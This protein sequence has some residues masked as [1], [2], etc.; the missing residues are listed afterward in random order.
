MAQRFDPD[1]LK[2]AGEATPLVEGILTISGAALAVFSTSDSGLLAYNSGE[3]SPEVHLEWRDR[4]GEILSTV[5]EPAIFG[6]IALSPDGSQVISEIVE[7]GGIGN[8]W[9]TDLETGLRNR[10]TFE[11]MSNFGL[12]W[13]SDGEQLFFSALHN[14]R[15]QINRKAVG[16]VGERESLVDREEDL[17]LCSV[18][19]DERSVLIHQTRPGTSRDLMILTIGESVES[20]AFRETEADERC[21]A[22]SPDGRWVAYT[23]NESGRYEIY[24]AP[25]P[26]TGRR[27][28]VSQEGGLFPQW[29]SDGRE[30]VYTRRNG[31]L[32]AAE[33]AT[34][35]DSLQPSGTK[36]L[37]RIHPPIPDG[38]SF[39][40]APD[41]EK[42][43]V[44]SNRQRDSETVV[45]LIVN[46]PA[47]LDD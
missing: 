38:P 32:V 41:G 36:V 7:P 40:L 33:I 45:N 39:A 37:F 23:S 10:F 11:T 25:F 21:G 4:S 35:A 30:I 34:G 42:L 13:S 14:S 8:L 15:F 20:T 17:I 44:W 1:L 16:G 24:V 46:W 6:A 19:P 31:E 27:W 29:R 18:S 43:L 3:L 22:F 9:L 28:Q 47:E 2:L 26:W 5:G 12:D